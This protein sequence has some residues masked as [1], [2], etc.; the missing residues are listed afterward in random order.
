MNIRLGARGRRG[1]R[2]AL[3]ITLALTGFVAGSLPAHAADAGV[4]QVGADPCNSGSS[5]PTFYSNNHRMAVTDG[6]RQLAVYD[7]HGTGVTLKWRDPDGTWKGSTSG[8]VGDG[9]FPTT[10]S[11]I[12]R[13]ASIAAAHDPVTRA[14]HA[15]VVYSSYSFS[16]NKIGAVYLRRL[17]DLDDPAGPHVG[18]EVMLTP[19]GLGHVRVDLAFEST[20]TGPRGVI[21]WMRRTADSSYQI[22]TAWLSDLSETPTLVGQ[23]VHYTTSTN[24]NTSTLTPTASGVA[25]VARTNKLRMFTHSSVDPLTT[26]GGG[27]GG[28]SASAK[29]R[30]SAV[31]LASGDVLSAV[32]SNTTSHIVKVVRFNSTGAT[33]TTSLETPTGY[34]QPSIA[35]N[36][37]D[38]W[39]AMVRSSNDSVVT[40]RMTGPSWGGD[41]TEITAAAGGGDFASPNLVRTTDT[42]LRMLVDGKRCPTSS[43]RNAVIAYQRPL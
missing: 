17:S 29:S 42:H 3:A 14:Q 8:A 7:P 27:G 40:R 21:T 23:T 11:L 26:W 12:D 36:G 18:P 33:A 9:H 6:G 39:V 13:P 25:L 15:W 20:L 1:T 19:A 37:T 10:N 38:A 31:A 4:T 30:P 2:S 16:S 41:V 34:L 35:T 5:N 24:Q 43:R 32:E 28:V 22:V